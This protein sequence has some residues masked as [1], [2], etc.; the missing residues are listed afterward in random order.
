MAGRDEAEFE[1][2]VVLD[3]GR[4]LGFALL[5]GLAAPSSAKQ[6]LGS[7]PHNERPGCLVLLRV[8]VHVG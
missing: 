7:R 3:G 5:L 2:Y 8:N 1:A 6:R 4:L